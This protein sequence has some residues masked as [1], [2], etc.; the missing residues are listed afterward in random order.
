MST[1]S[2]LPTTAK[3]WIVANK[4]T[5]AITDDVHPLPPFLQ[6]HPC[7]LLAD[8]NESSVGQVFKVEER[9]LGELKEGEILIRVE[10]LFVPAIKPLPLFVSLRNTRR[11]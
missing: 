6:F 7:R 2:N 1:P 3:T 9:A 10:H 8:L 5:S 11:D 4:P